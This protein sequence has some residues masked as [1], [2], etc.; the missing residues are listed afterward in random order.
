NY[1]ATAFPR[2][3]ARCEIAG[4]DKIGHGE[5]R[6]RGRHGVAGKSR[7]GN[8]DMIADGAVGD[9][10]DRVNDGNWV[11]PSGVKHDEFAPADE[12]LTG[13]AHAQLDGLRGRVAVD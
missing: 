8:Q 2:E 12:V 7:T 3:T 11:E 10:A 1:A 13:S 5:V 4:R 6:D 9:I